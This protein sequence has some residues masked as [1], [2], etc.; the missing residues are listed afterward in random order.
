MAGRIRFQG[1]ELGPE[2]LQNGLKKNN[3]F[4]EMLSLFLCS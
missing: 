1:W 2:K 3:F 4:I